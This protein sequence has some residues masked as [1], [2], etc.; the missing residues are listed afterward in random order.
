MHTTDKRTA[1]DQPQPND[2][3]APDAQPEQSDQ[4]GQQPAAADAEATVA[5]FAAQPLAPRQAPQPLPEQPT[6]QKPAPSASEQSL[7]AQIDHLGWT[8]EHPASHPAHG[9][10]ADDAI[11][12]QGTRKPSKLSDVPG[13]AAHVGSIFADGVSAMRRMNDAHRAYVEA[14]AALKKL[15]DEIEEDTDLLAHRRDVE[16]NYPQVASEQA[17]ASEA[18]KRD[19]ETATEKQQALANELTQL[20]ARLK[21]MEEADSETEAR[22][23]DAWEEARAGEK[24]AHDGMEVAERT[25]AE[26]EQALDQARGRQE[27]TVGAAKQALEDATAELAQLRQEYA[28]VQ[29]NPSANSAEYSVRSEELELKISDAAA[30]R[31]KAEM[32]VPRLSET[33]AAAVAAAERAVAEAREPLAQAEEFYRSAVEAVEKAEA[34]LDNARKTAERR[35]K[36]LRDEVSANRKEQRKQEQAAEEARARREVAETLLAEA[37]DVHNHPEETED[38]A[39]HVKQLAA[40]L[41]ERQRAVEALAEAEK[42][43]RAQTHQQRTRLCLALGAL[44]VLIVLVAIIANALS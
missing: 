39:A 43:V 17:A 6:Q 8:A 14:K 21:A 32:D 29:R 7:E 38:L 40:E 20:E 35:Q 24:S 1:T 44:V 4:P 30:A 10:S 12:A 37:E 41:E 15:Q 28:A 27:R 26:A 19:L 2:Q 23:R 33:A 25:L 3:P 18:A 36:S 9:L 13:A 31:T 34:E 22:L 11:A 16:K 42:G 5:D